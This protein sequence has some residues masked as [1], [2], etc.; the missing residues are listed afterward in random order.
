[1]ADSEPDGPA[2]SSRKFRRFVGNPWL[3]LAI[4]TGIY[5]CN[6]MDR[7]IPQIIAQQVKQEFALTDGEVGLFL[8]AAYGVPYGICAL[9]LGRAVD[10]FSRRNLIV[11]IVSI[12]SAMTALTGFASSYLVLLVARAGVGAAE[13]GSL[14]AGLSIISDIFPPQ[15]RSTAIGLYK[16]ALALGFLLSSLV[17]AH[18]GS[19][20][21]WRAT[22]FVAAVPGFALA[23]LLF[24]FTIE[25]VRGGMDKGG[26]ASVEPGSYGAAFHFLLASRQVA[27]TTIAVMIT[28]F[29][30]SA[31][32][33]FAV[34]FLQ[35][36][37]GLNVKE[38][39]YYFAL[40]ASF[41]VL[42]P[43]V[44]GF[45]ADRIVPAGLDRAFIF[46]AL[47]CLIL[48]AAALGVAL[49]PQL[50]VVIAALTLWQFVALGLSAPI[51]GV[52][53]TMAGSG[54]RGTV[55]AIMMIGNMAVGYGTG[56]VIIGLLSD[57]IG[58]PHSIGMA[59]ALLSLLIYPPASF[60]FLLT[61]RRIKSG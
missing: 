31:L 51:Y 57:T 12:W 45:I 32:T 56:P 2:L 13:S 59:M 16:A 60:L 14:P 50:G 1:M 46:F 28:S 40:T 33:A 39:S 9:L 43:I 47:L 23:L 19:A 54:I 38:A 24:L 27:P 42:G 55:M 44:L 15:R 53:L 3:T 49:V 5:V 30:G 6:V 29:V 4:L 10:T 11:I 21:G 34:M 20:Y 61:A 17:V 18:I 26:A 35:R 8:G 58:G 41:A 22:F 37:H 36:E 52:L 48:L 25:P 7:T